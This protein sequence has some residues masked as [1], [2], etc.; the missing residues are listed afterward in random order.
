MTKCRQGPPL[1]SF[2]SGWSS[3]SLARAGAWMSLPPVGKTKP[4][5]A[6]QD[7]SCHVLPAPVTRTVTAELSLTPQVR[8][9]V[10]T[11]VLSL[12]A[13]FLAGGCCL[14]CL[15]SP[16]ANRRE[17]HERDDDSC[18]ASLPFPGLGCRRRALLHACAQLPRRRNC[19]AAVPAL[20][21]V[22]C[23]SLPSRLSSGQ[24]CAS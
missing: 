22:R 15:A 9:P 18:E 17:P 12:R 6:G 19:G 20:L 21:G 5:G 3:F 23:R 14:P 13:S 16:A 7:S 8:G 24:V 4:Q 11:R 2:S 10:S 1:L